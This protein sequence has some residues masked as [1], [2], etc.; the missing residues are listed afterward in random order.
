[1][2]LNP[3]CPRLTA[4]QI[5]AKYPPRN[6]CPSMGLPES[7]VSTSSVLLP[8][9]SNIFIFT[10]TS[11]GK[12]KITGLHP[13]H[14]QR[15]SHILISVLPIALEPTGTPTATGSISTTPSETPT[16]SSSSSSVPK[17]PSNAGIITGGVI[18]GK[19]T[20]FS[21]DW[22]TT[23]GRSGR[24]CCLG[25]YRGSRDFISHPSSRLPQGTICGIQHI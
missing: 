16:P 11:S 24:R 1:M 19:S 2:V 23:D 9:S 21:R 14:D 7:Y 5:S 20:I 10:V 17:K 12:A 3:R 6:H 25:P 4:Y 8:K 22:I 13:L 15:Y 18:S